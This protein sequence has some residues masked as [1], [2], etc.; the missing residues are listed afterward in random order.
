MTRSKTIKDQSAAAKRASTA[1]RNLVGQM[2]NE[3][4]LQN[5]SGISAA[6]RNTLLKAASILTG[7]GSTKAA[8]AEK[9]K[10][11]EIA[12]DKALA[13]TTAEASAI[14][15]QWAVAESVLDKVAFIVAAGQDYSLQRYLSEGLPLWGGRESTPGDWQEMLDHVFE[16]CRKELPASVG[17]LAIKANVPT[18]E[19]MK[20]MPDKLALLKLKPGVI[21]LAKRWEEKI[22]LV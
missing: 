12:R 17:Y 4:V 13:K 5:T 6:D 1:I 22:K 18:I 14:L 21:A 11:A 7:I 9:A 20:T 3:K 19:A 8:A 10:V 16:D 15:A 2:D